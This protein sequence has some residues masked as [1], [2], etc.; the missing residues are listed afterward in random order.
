MN[1]PV[2]FFLT[3][4]PLFSLAA[5]KGWPEK[6]QEIKY[7]STADQTQQPA[8]FYVPPKWISQ[9]LYW[10]GCTLGQAIIVRP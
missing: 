7:L 5:P 6:I 10:S 4:I 9:G 3:L 2:I 8:L 1:Y